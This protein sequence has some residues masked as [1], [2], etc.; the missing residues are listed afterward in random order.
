MNDEVIGRIRRLSP[1]IKIVWMG[2]YLL[3]VAVILIVGWLINSTVENTFRIKPNQLYI[4]IL[5]IA[6]FFF[7]FYLVF[8]EIKY[9]H[10][11]YYFTQRGIV[12]EKGI[13]HKEKYVVPYE[14]IQNINI[15][16][17][18]P[19]RIL[20]IGKIII[21]TAGTNLKES[22]T[23]LDG[24]DDPEGFVKE[25]IK[26][27][28]AHSGPPTFRTEEKIEFEESK[29]EIE[30]LAERMAELLKRVYVLEER[31]KEFEDKLKLLDNVI[32]K[33]K[34]AKQLTDIKGKKLKKKEKVKKKTTKPKKK[35][36]KKR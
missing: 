22:E 23:T 19:L 20:G 14:K 33:E 36:R 35:R 11:K 2:K 5:A 30:E 7:I 18:I 10:F 24:I 28:E 8:I 1:K 4:G 25:A 29:E 9:R 26:E 31:I 12:I 6:T 27:V 32:L 15:E 13:L 21:E 17:T 34:A 3:F 16:Y